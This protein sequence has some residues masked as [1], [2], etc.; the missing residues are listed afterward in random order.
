MMLFYLSDRAQALF[1]KRFPLEATPAELPRDSLNWSVEVRAVDDVDGKQVPVCVLVEEVTQFGLLFTF[2]GEQFVAHFPEVFA[3]RLTTHL[4]ALLSNYRGHCESELEHLAD[5]TSALAH[6]ITRELVFTRGV[7]SADAARTIDEIYAELKGTA[8]PDSEAAMVETESRLNTVP[9]AVGHETVLPYRD[10]GQLMSLYATTRM[11]RD[12][13]EA[14]RFL[15]QLG[16][17]VGL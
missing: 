14:E 6:E 16:K 1:E 5:L 8:L 17:S 2:A 7:T 3:R 15:D 10:F 4:S 13:A 9:R 12:P 11:M